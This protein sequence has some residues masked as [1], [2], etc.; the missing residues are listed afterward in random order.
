[1]LGGGFRGKLIWKVREGFYRPNPLKTEERIQPFSSKRLGGLDGILK[2]RGSKNLNMERTCIAC[3]AYDVIPGGQTG[4]K[5]KGGTGYLGGD[6]SL[7]E[8]TWGS[9]KESWS[10][11]HGKSGLGE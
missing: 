5:A 2:G 10:K 9:K 1:V 8:R 4:R 7:W 6:S 3:Y 11:S